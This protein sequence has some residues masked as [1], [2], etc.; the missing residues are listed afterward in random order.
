M[1]T[2]GVVGTGVPTIPRSRNVFTG[3]RAVGKAGKH[4]AA[5]SVPTL[6]RAPSPHSLS[7]TPCPPQASH[8]LRLPR[9]PAVTPLREW[10]SLATASSIASLPAPPARWADP[11]GAVHTACGRTPRRHHGPR[12]SR[13]QPAVTHVPQPREAGRGAQ[14]LCPFCQWESTGEVRSLLGHTDMTAYSEL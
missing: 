6:P 13:R 3:G 14:T 9:Q 11:V 2:L 10:S 1:L 4:S 8:A 12:W 5:E 7:P